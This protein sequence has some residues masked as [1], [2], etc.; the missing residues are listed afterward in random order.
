MKPQ[1]GVP[2]PD[3]KGVDRKGMN[4][5]GLEHEFS[6]QATPELSRTARILP[7]PPVEK[8]HRDLILQALDIR[9]CRVGG[10]GNVTG[11]H[12]VFSSPGAPTLHAPPKI[13]PDKT[14]QLLRLAAQDNHRMTP[15]P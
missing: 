12:P 5:V 1:R 13:A 9:N 8:E 4:S 14:P 11:I 7:Q 10:T 3:V 15:T 2:L 6:G